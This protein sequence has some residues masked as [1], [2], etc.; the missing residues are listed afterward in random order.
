MRISI[1]VLCYYWKNNNFPV[2]RESQWGYP[3]IIHCYFYY[4]YSPKN[5]F[6]GLVRFAP[7][8][9]WSKWLFSH[10]WYNIKVHMKVGYEITY[11]KYQNNYKLIFLAI[12]LF[13]TISPTLNS[14]TVLT[15]PFSQSIIT[16]QYCFRIWVCFC[17]LLSIT[18]NVFVSI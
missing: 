8:K 17:H 12:V 3:Y 14:L 5:I 2:Q 1:T 15:L 4:W 13:V 9:F 7:S 18:M 11:F 16:F 6:S 10:I